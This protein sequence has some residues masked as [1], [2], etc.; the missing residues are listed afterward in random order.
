MGDETQARPPLSREQFAELRR[1]D[2]IQE[3]RGRRRVWTVTSDAREQGRE[4][5]VVIRTGDLVRV[6]RGWF[7]DDYTLF[8]TSELPLPVVA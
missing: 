4:C 1:G 3:R 5:L 2:T 7:A 8:E 6:E